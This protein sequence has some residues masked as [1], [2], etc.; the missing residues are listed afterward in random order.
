[1]SIRELREELKDMPGSHELV[2]DYED[3]GKV[4]VFRMGKITVRLGPMATS[5]QVKAALLEA[6][7]K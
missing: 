2:M 7:D 5:A 1:M 4:Q 3:G 6:L